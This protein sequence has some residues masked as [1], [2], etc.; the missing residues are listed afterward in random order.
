MP[1]LSFNNV[2]KHFGAHDVLSGINISV[3]PS[4]KI[5]LIGA[6]GAGKTTIL[7]LILGSE[8]PSGGNVTR[9]HNARVGYVPQ[10]PEFPEKC[11]VAE[12]LELDLQDVKMRL[13]NAEES[14]S[15]AGEDAIEKALERYQEARDAYDAM[16]GDAS[17]ERVSRVLESFGL[18]GRQD[19]PAATLSGGELN[20]LSLARATFSRPD[21]L[22]LD[23]P[24]NHLDY[25]GLG[26]LEEYLTS[27]PAAVLL[28]SHNRYLLDR[29]VTTIFELEN[30][31]ITVYSGNYS[32]YRRTKL[33]KLV[34][35]QSDY[36]ANQKRLAR[37]EALVKRFE[38]IA[39]NTADPKWGQRY[40]SRR[41]QLEKERA[42]AVERPE[43]DT[44]SMQL[45]WNGEKSKADIALQIKNYTAGFGE[46]TLFDSAQLQFSCG[47]RVALVGPN[48][49]GKTTLLR[50]IVSR[51]N[52]D[53]P[54][55]RIGPSLTVGYCAQN[56][57]VF[58]PEKT[59]LE[60]FV[61][62]GGQNRRTVFL[63]LSKFLFGWEELDKRIGSLSGGELNRLQLARVE[64]LKANFLILDEP[65][66]HLDI[67]SREAIEEALDEFD[68][69]LLVVSHDRYFLD[70]IAD[71]IVEIDNGKLEIFNGNFSEFW[72][73]HKS[74]QPRGG[75]MKGLGQ[76]RKAAVFKTAT[77]GA[78]EKKAVN[79]NSAVAR[80]AAEIESRIARLEEERA[81]LESEITEAFA[82]G[83]H[84]LG[85]EKSNKLSSVSTRIE[86]L[87]DE[88]SG[89]PLA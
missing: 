2:S 77:G 88:W 33:Q 37:L 3:E 51:G 28:V 66:N 55:L 44:R 38:Q 39:R 45:N 64:A 18:G 14:L 84:K 67:G 85:R 68:G 76:R 70:K 49:S 4:A 19:Q 13:R 89:L 73:Q 57:D 16:N 35:T 75:T 34:N 24:G 61:E 30:G 29:V 63:L 36:V 87:F 52:W 8:S 21:L 54:I 80:Q 46:T 78:T 20:T 9:A 41:T 15:T 74:T 26:W 42:Q 11:T 31:G 62:L 53:D 59:I 43:L 83:D 82:A 17:L 86:K 56:Q 71:R 60:T 23:E 1:I 50:D 48:G 69:T 10:Y 6:N 58:D 25:I 12:A 81:I 72:Q 5:G 32:E 7:K 65:T 27:F 40:R 22:V 47:E 79:K